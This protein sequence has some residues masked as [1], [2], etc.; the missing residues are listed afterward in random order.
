MKKTLHFAL[1][2]LTGCQLVSPRTQVYYVVSCP[3]C[4][5]A[6]DTPKGR[7]SL[8]DEPAI[9]RNG[10]RSETTVYKKNKVS[11]E[12]ILRN[13]GAGTVNVQVFFDG[14]QKTNFSSV[15]GAGFSTM[16]IQANN[17]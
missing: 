9:T 12:M 6:Y 14:K 4:S 3:K 8:D 11:V 7:I 5:M 16:T 2:L 17:L 13:Q 1:F 15:A 10:W